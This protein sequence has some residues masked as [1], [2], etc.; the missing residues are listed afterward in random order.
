MLTRLCDLVG[1]SG[2]VLEWFSSYLSGRSF[3]VYANEFLSDPADLL[4]GVPQGSVLGPILFLLYILPLKKI[5]QT[6]DDVSYHLFADDIQLYCSFKPSEI[7]KLSSLLK[8][9]AQVKQWLGANSL[10]LNPDKTEVLV[11]APDDAI[12]GIHQYLGDL[13]LSAKTSLRN[14]GIIFDKAMSL[15]HHSKLLTRNCFYQLR[16][17]SKL[18]S[19]VSRDDLEMIIHAFVSSRLDYCNSLF[20]CLNKKALSR[21]QQVQNSTARL[22]TRTNR[23]AHITPILKALHWLPVTFRFNFKILVLTFRA[24]HGQAPSYITDLLCPY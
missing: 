6:F 11:F 7:Q 21:L 17:I 5:I 19:L 1:M 3:S 18:R 4:C 15:E 2:P 12:P 24:L 8:C 20:S 22:L 13:S 10:Q 16:K 23:R 9:L 14:L